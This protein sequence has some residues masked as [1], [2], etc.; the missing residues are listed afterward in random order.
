MLMKDCGKSADE[1]SHLTGLSKSNVEKWCSEKVREKILK[2]FRSEEE[3]RKNQA[4]LVLISEFL[5]DG[6]SFHFQ[7]KEPAKLK[8]FIEIL[9][10]R[11]QQSQLIHQ[12]VN[13]AIQPKKLTKEAEREDQSIFTNLA[14][15]PFIDAMKGGRTTHQQSPFR[16]VY[17]IDSILQYVIDKGIFFGKG[18]GAA[19]DD[20]GLVTSG[21]MP[22]GDEVLVNASLPNDSVIASPFSSEY[23]SSSL[24]MDYQL[25]HQQFSG[26]SGMNLGNFI[27]SG[28]ESDFDMSW[29]MESDNDNQSI[30]SSQWMTSLRSPVP[31]TA[32]SLSSFAQLPSNRQQQ[33]QLPK[34][35]QNSDKKGEREAEDDDSLDSNDQMIEE[36]QQQEKNGEDYLQSL[37][38]QGIIPKKPPCD[39][40]CKPIDCQKELMKKLLSATG[41]LPASITYKTSEVT[42]QYR[43]KI[44]FP[45]V[46]INSS[47]SYDF[48]FSPS[49]SMDCWVSKQAVRGVLRNTK[50]L[51]SVK[52]ILAGKVLTEEELEDETILGMLGE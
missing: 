41:L 31:P 43:G 21:E 42:M 14:E 35:I 52:N 20:E 46:P 9:G 25:Q 48:S 44:K 10:Q 8:V 4:A 5:K 24:P 22:D 49:I 7:V 47:G 40:C 2:E 34:E 19:N 33:L 16:T 17:S 50:Y 45:S 29:L 18:T 6:S 11:Y 1:I 3:K 30:A 28:E 12:K 38:H 13:S 23:P 15:Q 51:S 26:N 37:I 39:V 36:N 32:S 27:S